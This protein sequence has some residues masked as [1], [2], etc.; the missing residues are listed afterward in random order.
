MPTV[1]RVGSLRFVIW[2]NDHLPPHVHVISEGAEATIEL[3]DLDGSPC[4][5][6][7]FRMKRSDLTMA[8]RA[9]L[10]HR[11]FLLE[12]RREIHG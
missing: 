11:D 12:K 1:L 8:L 10:E 4:L 5:A 6:E 3:G 7:N 9:A 2:P